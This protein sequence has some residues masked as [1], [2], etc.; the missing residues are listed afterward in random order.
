VQSIKRQL[1]ALPQE[2]IGYGLLRYGE[3]P[4]LAARLAGLPRAEASF[5]YLGGLGERA[6]AAGG[7]AAAPEPTGPAVAPDNPRSHL[8]EIQA[9]LRGERLTVA[10]TYGRHRHR[11]ETVERRAADFLAALRALI[12]GCGAGAAAAQTPADFPHADV[13]QGELDELLAHFSQV[14]G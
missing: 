9:A 10:F 2:G 4:E 14:G 7:F 6:A 5:L 13:G 11:Q 3:R 1:R 8:L 12:R